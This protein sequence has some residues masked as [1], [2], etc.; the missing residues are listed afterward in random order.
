MRPKRHTANATAQVA[1]KTDDPV[2]HA[3][4]VDGSDRG[5]QPGGDVELLR[6]DRDQLDAANQEGDGQSRDDDVLLW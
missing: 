1:R 4:E 3:V 6:E 2:A 5:Q